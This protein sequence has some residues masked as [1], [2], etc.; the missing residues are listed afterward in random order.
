MDKTEARVEQALV[1]TVQELAHVAREDVEGME[2]ALLHA[3]QELG[4]SEENVSNFISEDRASW[5]DR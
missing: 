1:D 3:A 4:L 5:A 2:R